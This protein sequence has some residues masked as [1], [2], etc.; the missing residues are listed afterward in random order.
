MMNTEEALTIASELLSGWSWVTEANRPEPN[1]LDVILSSPNDLIPMV[2]G[3]RVKRLGYLAA[4]T[5]LDLGSE[6]GNLEVLYH[7]CAGAAVIT[8]RLRVPREGAS[9]PSLCEIIPSAEG[10][11]R[12]LSEMFGV[13]V[14]GLH[15][16]DKLYL[17]DDWPV[18]VYPLCKDADLEALHSQA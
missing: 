6:S 18:G 4:I 3:L 14:V 1:R 10:F 11:E 8:L 16:P 17:P 7:F 13:T 5:G 12:E 2:V 15:G 9:V